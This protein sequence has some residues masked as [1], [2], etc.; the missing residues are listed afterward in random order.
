MQK[1]NQHIAQ[2]LNKL[3]GKR[4]F[5]ACSGGLD[6]ICLTHLLFNLN[7]DLH[8]IHVN[9]Q[10]RGINSD[11]DANFVEAFCE[12]LGIPFEKRTINLSAQLKDGGNLQEVARN[13]RYD[14]FNEILNENS[15]N[16][17]LL[18]H[19][20]NDQV[21]TFFLNLGRKSGVMGLSCMPEE[22]HRIYRP[23]LH[24]AKE[25]LLEYAT[26]ENIEWR[27]DASNA[28]SKYRRNLLRNEILPFL[29]TNIIGLNDSVLLLIQQFQNKQFALEA[30]TS[31]ILEAIIKNQMIE[32][33]VIQN[34][35]EF[36][37]VEFVRQLQQPAS[38]ANEL[39]NL[40]VSQKG[41]KVELLP[42]DHFSAIVRER[43]TLTFVPKLQNKRN[44][45]LRVE[46]V[47]SLP[48]SYSKDKLYLDKS[49]IKGALKIRPWQ[50]GDRISPIGMNGTKLISDIIAEA[51]ITADKKKQI[52]VVHDDLSIHWCVG[53]KVGKGAIASPST[54]E[55][56]ECSFFISESPK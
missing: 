3:H 28:S 15:D 35:D 32:I 33:E 21:E 23:L 24:Y 45:L 12:K 1:L 11:E 50:L 38:I 40:L 43:S 47:N 13:Y 4:L 19:H 9:Y 16:V 6:S 48:K 52:L 37:V 39:K 17:V 55:I 49:K 20:A 53:L 44:P 22:H 56:L 2:K 46:L 34:M 14:W 29:N 25:D 18:A 42:N 54:K 41:K 26:N 5:V 51:L 8:I 10:L 7:F 31:P 27:E 30:S 36:E